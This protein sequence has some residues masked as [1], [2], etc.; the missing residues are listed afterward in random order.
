VVTF[1]L[2]RT[3]RVR[4][5]LGDRVLELEQLAGLD[6]LARLS[7]LDGTEPYWAYLWPSAR[8]LARVVGGLPDLTGKRVLDLGCGLGAG[9]LAAAAR[10]ADVVLAD[11]VPQAVTLAERNA[12]LNG[13]RVRGL[14]LDW[15]TPPAELGQFDGIV[16]ADVFYGDGM[17][18]GVVRFIKGHLARDGLAL[19]T[20]PMRV[21]PA[22]VGGA[23]RLRGLDTHA[24]ELVPGQTMTGGVTLY[25]LRHR[26]R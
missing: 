20:D 8:A 15:N 2:E 11:R 6:R 21:M 25:Q 19:L 17:L 14:V 3:E 9:G 18:S 23:A 1:D 10:G 22:G 16:A 4:V 26:P 13:L 12:A 5:D 7:V 24:V